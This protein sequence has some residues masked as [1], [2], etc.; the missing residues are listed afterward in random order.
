MTN[1]QHPRPPDAVVVGAG[2]AGLACALDLI[3]AG[4]RVELLE[5]SDGVGGRMRTD[6]RD[7]FRLDRGFQVFNT[8]YPQVKK[9]LDLRALRLRPFTP[10]LV[11]RTSS[12]RVRL[13]DPTRRPG[14]AGALLPGR[15]LPARDLAA[16]AALTA[17]D[18]LLPAKRVGRMTDRTAAE[19]LVRAGLSPLAI[20]DLLRPFLSGVFLEEGLETSARF[21]HLVWRSMARGTLCLPAHGI[22]AVPAQLAAG[23]PEGA[24]RL[25]SAV[26][27]V[28]D[29]GVLLADG[30]E[31]PGGAVVVATDSATA[32]RLLPG[33][34]VPDGRTVTTYYHAADR[35]PLTE[36]TLVVD[37]GLA[38][39]NSCVLTEVAPSY[40]PRG[41]ALVSTSVLGSGPPG[42]ERTV[43]AR[44]A[45]LYDADTSTW[46]T[47]AAYT[48]EGALPAMRPPWP[49]SRTTRFAPGRYVCGDH[50]A[51][52]SVQG[53]LASGSRAA[54]EVLADRA[55]A[56]TTGT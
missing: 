17:R 47:V 10:G 37:S 24:L 20:E 56:R 26:T 4:L 1:R 7:G 45:E 36:P 6:R 21:L 18:V 11:A 12:G 54:R 19:A 25:D 2:L 9:R 27:G 48:V 55:A 8:S 13:T 14:D 34:P 53:A 41:T 33:L 50:R 42:G 22:G 46:E 5:A 31:R 38:V 52:G 29:S 49:L 16:L 35:S 28:T 30:G 23:L 51:T 15:V 40:A 32:A 44:L 39:L 43:R 3:R